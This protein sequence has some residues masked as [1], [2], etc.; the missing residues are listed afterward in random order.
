MCVT[1]V[2]ETESL[3][4]LVRSGNLLSKHKYFNEKKHLSM[5]KKNTDIFIHKIFDEYYVFRVENI[6]HNIS[7]EKNKNISLILN[8]I[9]IMNLNQL[10][11][12]N[13]SS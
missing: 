2:A 6:L 9:M 12:K 8:Y 11:H 13:Y 4:C 3:F 5:V 1:W 7:S 10:I